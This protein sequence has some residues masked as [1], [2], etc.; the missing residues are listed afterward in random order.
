MR[1]LPRLK[2]MK[3]IHKG[4]AIHPKNQ[5]KIEALANKYKCSQSYVKATII[6]EYFAS[7]VE[8]KYYL[9]ED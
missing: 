2:G 5:A 1:I 6:D 7:D 9:Q 4:G 3:R 8:A